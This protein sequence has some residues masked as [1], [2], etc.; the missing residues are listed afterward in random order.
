MTVMNAKNETKMNSTPTTCAVCSNL[1]HAP[2]RRS[3]DGEIV[4]GCISAF[5]TGHIKAGTP[6]EAWHNRDTAKA[7]RA[8]SKFDFNPATGFWCK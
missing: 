4:E 8:K 7:W 1:P 2:Y 5:H 3:V 6:D